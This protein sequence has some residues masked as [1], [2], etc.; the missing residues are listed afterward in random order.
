MAHIE[1]KDGKTAL[2][3]NETE[4]RLL[5]NQPQEF[6]LFSPK[7]GLLVLTE[8]TMI[9][10]VQTNNHVH[11]PSAVAASKTMASSPTV[12]VPFPKPNPLDE[13][14]FKILQDRKQL[15][16]RIVGKFEKTLN[17]EENKRLSELQKEGLVEKFKLSEQYKQPI[18]RLNEKKFEERLEKQNKPL[19][20]KT[21]T[22]A[23]EPQ[24]N[25]Y[26]SLDRD[27]YAILKTD[28]EARTISS[29]RN[30]DFKKGFLKGLKSFDGTFFVIQQN[31][32][33]KFQLK[34][35]GFLEKQRKAD[36]ALICQNTQLQP[37]AVRIACEFLKEDGQVFEKTKNQ[38]A[39]V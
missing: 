5:E 25:A 23:Q 14:L 37:E 33:H 34:I 11:A 28:E 20:N 1:K 15:S 29:V 36:L 24:K 38:F 22:G 4:S 30:E 26:F 7:K 8:K 10:P 2:V 16:S 6:D 35:L 32:L 3:L 12:Q 21:G 18:Y 31:A 9:N 13:K 27:G 39:L 19:Q 17:E